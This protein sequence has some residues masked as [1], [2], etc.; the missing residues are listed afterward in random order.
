[1]RKSEESHERNT[2]DEDGRRS[3]RYRCGYKTIRDVE[4]QKFQIRHKSEV[5]KLR[6]K[7]NGNTER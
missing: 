7:R 2:T 3:D 1:M 4:E 5:R 6:M